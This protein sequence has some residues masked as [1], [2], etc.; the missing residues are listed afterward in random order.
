METNVRGQARPVAG[1]W[2]ALFQASKQ[3]TLSTVRACVVNGTVG[4]KVAVR[5]ALAGAAEAEQQYLAWETPVPSGHP[6]SMTEGWT[7]KEDDVLW[8]SSLRGSVSF[9]VFGVERD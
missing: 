1:Q 7:L 8:V 5:L 2:A 9:S 4:D 6:Y 3:T